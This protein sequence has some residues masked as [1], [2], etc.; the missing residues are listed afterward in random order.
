MLVAAGA[1]VL[2]GGGIGVRVFVGGFEPDDEPPLVGVGVLVAAATEVGCA[3]VA[4][5][6][7]VAVA[8]SLSPAGAMRAVFSG[9][10]VVA[11]FAVVVAT[12][13]AALVDVPSGWAVGDATGASGSKSPIA[14][15]RSTS[16]CM[17]DLALAVAVGG[18]VNTGRSSTLRVG[19]GAAVSIAASIG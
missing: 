10:R 13:V 8:S 19:R 1:R 3:A 4:A 5:G 18:S 6:M 11:V 16:G 17:T 9:V 15:A 2:V 12:G 7:S 14:P